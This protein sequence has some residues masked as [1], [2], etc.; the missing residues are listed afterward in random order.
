MHSWCG[1]SEKWVEICFHHW[2]SEKIPFLYFF[3]HKSWIWQT[4]GHVTKKNSYRHFHNASKE[5][6]WP[7]KIFEF[8]ARVQKCHFGKNEKLPKWHFWTCAWN[9]NF[10]WPKS[11]FWSIME[12]AIRKFFCNMSQGL[13]NPGFMQEK[14]QKGDFL[15]CPMMKK[16]FN[17]FFRFYTSRV[18]GFC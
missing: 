16:N 9:S 12:M 7:K 1:E 11:F 5:C 13:P 10:F 8:H 6:F 14:V 18:H 4:L 17:P 15:W 2:T 3:L